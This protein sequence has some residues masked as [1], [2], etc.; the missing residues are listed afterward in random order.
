MPMKTFPIAFCLLAAG[1]AAQADKPARLQ[2]KQFLPDDYRLVAHADLAAMR[3]CGVWE[4]LQA[5][6]LKLAF[7]QMKKELGYPVD[8]LDRVTVAGDL[9]PADAESGHQRGPRTVFVIEGNTDLPL[10]DRLRDRPTDT[11]GGH[12]VRR[13]GRGTFVA[14]DGKA[15][16]EGDAE[17]VDPVLAG[18]PRAGQPC[19]DIMSLLSGRSGQLAYVVMDVANEHTKT[20]VTRLF[21]GGQWPE[22]EEPTFVCLR[23]LVLGE[24]DDPHLG[25]EAVLRHGKAGEGLATSEGL[26]DAMLTKM[27]EDAR[28]RSLKPILA[29]VEKRREAADLVYR[30]DFGRARDAVG[31]LATLVMPMFAVGEATSVQ[32]AAPAAPAAPAPVSPKK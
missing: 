16:V 6:A 22:G 10:H 9:P 26:A 5:S 1:L 21:P 15:S 14:L 30:A 29:K 23:V 12:E 25:L 31:H 8:Y 27:R 20:T 32:V 11:I 7:Q 4:E 19:A 3:A 17:L 24:P 18:K 13:T 2:A 28:L